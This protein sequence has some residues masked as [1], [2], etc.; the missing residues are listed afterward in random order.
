MKNGVDKIL[1]DFL[2]GSLAGCGRNLNGPGFRGG[3][4]VIAGSDE[5]HPSAHGSG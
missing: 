2:V 4:L 1:C 5:T 3:E